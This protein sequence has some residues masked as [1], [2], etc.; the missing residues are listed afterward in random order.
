MHPSIR[1]FDRLVLT[2]IFWLSNIAALICG[3]KG[4]WLWLAGAVLTSFC[5]GIVG[6]KIHPRQSFSDLTRGPLKNP[7]A[8]E[9]DAIPLEEQK[10]LVS[11]ACTSVGILVGMIVLVLLWSLASWRWYASIPVALLSTL[12]SGALLKVAFKAT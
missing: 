1:N 9:E 12:F 8:K 10:I 3:I 7:K 11:H 6:A 2:P 4:W 5:V